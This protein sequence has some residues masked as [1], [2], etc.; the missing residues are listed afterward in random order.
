MITS[1]LSVA[2]INYFKSGISTGVGETF[3]VM[4]ALYFVFMMFGVFTVRVPQKGW[5]RCFGAYQINS[6]DMQP[7]DAYSFS[8]Y[9][10]AGLL[11]VGFICNLMVKP[12]DE[13]FHHNE[14]VESSEE[15]ALTLKI[16]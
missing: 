6:M 8:M 15:K 9:I 10:M 14:E 11:I 1:P 7:A 3:L 12:V 16:R 4:G 2:L 5:N 13:R